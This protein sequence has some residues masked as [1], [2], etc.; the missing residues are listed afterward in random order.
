VA[1]ALRAVEDDE[2]VREDRRLASQLRRL[3]APSL[4]AAELDLARLGIEVEA[5]AEAGAPSAVVKGGAS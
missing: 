2:Q 5:G 3:G 4:C 1:D